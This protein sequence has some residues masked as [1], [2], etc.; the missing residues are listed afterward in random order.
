ML[1]EQPSNSFTINDEAYLKWCKT[2]W[3][4]N[5]F[6]FNT[7]EILSFGYTEEHFLIDLLQQF[8]KS[9]N[10]KLI[11]TRIEAA[12]LKARRAFYKAGYLQSEALMTIQINKLQEFEMPKLYTARLSPLSRADQNTKSRIIDSASDM[13]Q[14][15]RFHEDPLISEEMAACRMKNWVNDLLKKNTELL[16]SNDSSGKLNSYIFYSENKTNI[17]LILG[18]SLPERRAFSPFFFASLVQHFKSEGYTKIKT[19]ISFSNLGVIKIYL[20]LGFSIV[21]TSFDYHRHIS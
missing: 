10:L 3:D 11:Y 15:S 21:A 14:F 5:I 19:N 18:G 1:N 4:S 12:N 2:P 13:Y 8:E 7:A 6:G 16:I 20:S 9:S 17:E